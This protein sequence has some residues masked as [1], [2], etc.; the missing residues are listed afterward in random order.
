MPVVPIV[1]HYLFKLIHEIIPY[2]LN[3]LYYTGPFNY[4]WL[5]FLLSRL[6]RLQIY[7]FAYLLLANTISLILNENAVFL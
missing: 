2:Q 4:L 1:R 5:S 6:T 3:F 7:L